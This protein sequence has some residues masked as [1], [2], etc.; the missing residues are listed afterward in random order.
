M[1]R[2][3]GSTTYSDRDPFHYSFAMLSA[4]AEAVGGRAERLDDG[5]HPRGEAVM[6]ITRR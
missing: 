1:V 6:V 5:S 4:L 2:P 3:D